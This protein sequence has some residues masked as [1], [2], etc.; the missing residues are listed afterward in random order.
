MTH[1]LTLGLLY[2]GWEFH[3][4]G[5]LQ[6]GLAAPLGFSAAVWVQVLASC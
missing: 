3:F 4:R 2:L 6:Q 1:V 5:F